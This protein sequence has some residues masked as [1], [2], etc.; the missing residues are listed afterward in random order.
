[1][2]HYK[3]RGSGVAPYLGSRLRKWRILN[4]LLGFQLADLIGVASGS[5]SEIECNK[6]HPSANTLA[7]LLKKTNISVVWLLLNKGDMEI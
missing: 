3:I 7:K 4:K 6:T 1:M 5:L 2:Q